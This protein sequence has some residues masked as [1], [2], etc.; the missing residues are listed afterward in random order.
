[1]AMDPR[2]DS[3]REVANKERACVWQLAAA[4]QSG[5]TVKRTGALGVTRS[6]SRFCLKNGTFTAEKQAHSNLLGPPGRQT[7]WVLLMVGSL[8]GGSGL[9]CNMHAMQWAVLP[10][11]T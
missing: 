2:K 9:Y 8:N 6:L 7:T 5:P 3:A 10:V 11:L 4:L 1:M